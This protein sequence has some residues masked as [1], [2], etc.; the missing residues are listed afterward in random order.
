MT[1]TIIDAVQIPNGLESQPATIEAICRPIMQAQRLL[2]DHLAASRGFNPRPTSDDA[3]TAD[4]IHRAAEAVQAES[5]RHV[6]LETVRPII[7]QMVGGNRRS[8]RLGERSAP[9]RSVDE[10]VDAVVNRN[11]L[12][13]ALD[14]KLPLVAVAIAASKCGHIPALPSPETFMRSCV[15]ERQA[16][17]L[18]LDGLLDAKAKMRGR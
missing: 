12:S 14:G 15:K 6:T 9:E 7:E 11:A 5:Q 8:R 13:I 18:L 1:I 2:R 16:I 4:A 10:I 17:E 3:P